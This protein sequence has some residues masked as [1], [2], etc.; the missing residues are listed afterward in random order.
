[1]KE[2]RYIGKEEDTLADGGLDMWGWKTEI[3]DIC[4]LRVT[5][6]VYDDS[7]TLNPKL[8]C[9]NWVSRIISHI[10]NYHLC[11]W[12]HRNDIV[13]TTSNHPSTICPF[14][15]YSPIR[16]HSCWPCYI[17]RRPIFCHVPQQ[18]IPSRTQ[19]ATIFFSRSLLTSTTPH[20]R[21]PLLFS[22]T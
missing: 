22:T 17:A 3:L 19:L 18:A 16:A 1:M 6:C 13:H 15:V 7:L 10:Y 21:Y 2:K 5:L 14:L 20:T 8:L 11:I 9:R 12:G 4:Y